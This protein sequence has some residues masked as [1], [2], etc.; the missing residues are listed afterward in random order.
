MKGEIGGEFCLLSGVNKRKLL[1]LGC[2]EGR[3]D[4]LDNG[5][6]IGDVIGKGGRGGLKISLVDQ[7]RVQFERRPLL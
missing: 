7:S 3:F 6:L 4:S 5:C 2:I 1:R